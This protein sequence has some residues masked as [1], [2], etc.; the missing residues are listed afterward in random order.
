MREE[1]L[2]GGTKGGVTTLSHIHT[3][4]RDV[5]DNTYPP[6]LHPCLPPSC[7][8][9][10]RLLSP[11]SLPPYHP[12]LLFL[13]NYLFLSTLPPF[14]GYLTCLPLSFLSSSPSMLTYPRLNKI[15][16]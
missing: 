5:I 2:P 8:S 4:T 1:E 12:S 3:H 11:S 6:A 16:K 15:K 7:P 10:S 14:L 13:L 9:S